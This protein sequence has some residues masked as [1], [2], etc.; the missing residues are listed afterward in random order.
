MTKITLDVK[1]LTE[2]LGISSAT[3]YAM[4]REG[5]IPHF[6]LRGK[7]LFHRQVIEDWTIKASSKQFKKEVRA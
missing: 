2:L 4:V 6:K 1:E 3:V 7:I 5:Q